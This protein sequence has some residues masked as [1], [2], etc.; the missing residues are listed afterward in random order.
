VACNAAHAGS[1]PAAASSEARATLTQN[2]EL[3]RCASDG[4]PSA[5]VGSDDGE[6]EA[7]G[8]QQHARRFP[9][10][11]SR[12]EATQPGPAQPRQAQ[13][14]H[15]RGSRRDHTTRTLV[16]TLLDAFDAHAR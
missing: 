7:E 5:C 16:R 15:R 8:R 12:Q 10:R 6:T 4:G 3:R 9:R 1:I 13:V 14:A 11:S 2:L